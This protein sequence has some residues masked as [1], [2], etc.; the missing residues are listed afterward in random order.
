MIATI[1]TD[2][3]TSK[4]KAMENIHS[5]TY[6]L[7]IEQYIKDPRDPQVKIFTLSFLSFK[8]CALRDSDIHA[9]I[10]SGGHSS[11][12]PLGLE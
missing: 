6:S 3:N 9:A 8:G 5:E 12:N 10:N 11:G 1:H 7:L 2:T 4:T